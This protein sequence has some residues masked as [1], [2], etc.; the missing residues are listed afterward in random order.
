MENIK[1]YYIKKKE[2]LKILAKDKNLKLAIV[3]VGNNE[4]SN[5]YVRNKVKDANDCNISTEVIHFD[6]SINE[7]LLC[8]EI[9]NICDREDINGF[10][11]QLPLPE[12]FNERNIL[13]KI[14]SSKDVDGLSLFPKVNPATP[15][16]IVTY[17]EDN[18]Y[19][20]TDKNVL[21]IGRSYLVG[22]P[23]ANM[24]LKKNCNV[25][26][27]HSKT[28]LDNKIKYLS[29]ADLIICATGYRDTLTDAMLKNT[30]K[31][32]F[33]ID[34]GINFNENN[35]LVGDCEHVSTINKTPVPGGVGLLT[36]LA[37][38]ENILRLNCIL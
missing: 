11:L 13:D 30:N 29:L 32:A 19:D 25:T 1:D 6:S 31:K 8:S 27:I 16:G 12:G 22:K 5:R 18:N 2:K 34:V 35:K 10:I 26:I 17:L 4:A 38:I 20:F 28:S 9:K 15:Q 7:E 3:Q 33:I 21:I 23:L 37:V 36:R 14:N 24:L